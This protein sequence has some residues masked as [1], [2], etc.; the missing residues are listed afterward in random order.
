MKMK[1]GRDPEADLCRVRGA[2]A[3]IG[4]SNRLFVDANGAFNAKR[5]LHFAQ[6]F[7]ECN[8]E[9]F[10]E[11]TSSDDLEGLRFVRQGSPAGMAVTAGEYGYTPD[12]FRRMLAAD[13]VDVLQADASRCRGIT[14]FLTVSALCEAAAVPLSA[15]TAPSLHLAV[16][17]SSTPLIHLEWFHDHV[18]IERMLFD[19]A[20][21]PSNGTLQPSDA[22]GMGIEFRTRDAEKF[23]V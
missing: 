3:A 6:R 22:P 14:G 19:G 17:T 13:C 18:R 9:W 23:A 5:A 12:Y 7:A 1:V 16:C 11:P 4:S 8:V 20:V 15:H 21:Q 2:R 10:E